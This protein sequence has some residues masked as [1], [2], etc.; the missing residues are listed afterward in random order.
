LKITLEF[1]AE[2]HPDP[3]SRK[4]FQQMLSFLSPGYINAI[5]G[6]LAEIDEE[7]FF[8]SPK[9]HIPIVKKDSVKNDLLSAIGKIQEKLRSDTIEIPTIPSSIKNVQKLVDDPDLSMDKIAEYLKNDPIAAGR[10]ME[11][12]N[13]AYYR[14]GKETKNLKDALVKMGLS[15]VRKHLYYLSTKE[16][17][18]VSIDDFDVIAHKLFMHSAVS[19]HSAYMMAKLANVRNPEDVIL[20]VLFHDIGKFWAIKIIVKMIEKGEITLALTDTAILNLISALH[21]K[22]GGILLQKWGMP[23]NV[24]RFA[25][26]HHKTTEQPS[27]LRNIMLMANHMTKR[28]GYTEKIKIKNNIDVCGI[29]G[30]S[31]GSYLKLSGDM[32]KFAATYE[33]LV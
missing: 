1:L 27:K 4:V 17:F 16:L 7:A 10:I 18:T 24:V 14:T 31:K 22:L 20:P 29:V 19:S 6:V 23:R 11:L 13:S 26:D 30:I 28:I 15:T 9:K 12:S 8:S 5:N 21:E 3:E 25:V 33:G 32:R 2:N